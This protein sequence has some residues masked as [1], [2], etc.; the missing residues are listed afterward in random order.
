M[1][2]LSSYQPLI[3]YN[4]PFFQAFSLISLLNLFSILSLHLGQQIL[5]WNSLKQLKCTISSPYLSRLSSSKILYSLG[6][7]LTIYLGLQVLSY[8]PFSSSRSM[9]CL[10]TRQNSIFCL[11]ALS[12]LPMYIFTRPTHTSH[13]LVGCFLHLLIIHTFSPFIM[14][15]YILSVQGQASALLKNI[16]SLAHYL[17]CIA[18]LCLS[19]TKNLDFDYVL[20]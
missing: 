20:M 6:S 2:M 11:K 4:N 7:V 1:R 12:L 8:F 5:F 9:L 3:F 13:S 15:F 16:F 14:T 10:N 19:N 18:I 17:L